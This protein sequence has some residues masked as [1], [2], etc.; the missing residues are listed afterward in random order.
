M[1]SSSFNIPALILVSILGTLLLGCMVLSIVFAILF[2][3]RRN[4][5]YF[6]R[7]LATV[8]ISIICLLAPLSYMVYGCVSSLSHLSTR[9]EPYTPP[10]NNGGASQ[11]DYIDFLDTNGGKL[12]LIEVDG[13]G[14]T[15]VMPYGEFIYGS[16]PT[17]LVCD[18]S[19]INLLDY[20]YE[21]AVDVYNKLLPSSALT[22]PDFYFKET[23]YAPNVRN[24]CGQSP[25]FLNV[26]GQI[27]EYRK[28]LI[29]YPDGQINRNWYEVCPVKWITLSQDAY[30]IYGVS[31][32]VLDVTYF[33]NRLTN[34]DYDITHIN[35]YLNKDMFMLL[36]SVTGRYPGTKDI[37]T[38]RE[39][40]RTINLPTF[41]D[42]QNVFYHDKD[43]TKNIFT[44]YADDQSRIVHP[45]GYNVYA[46]NNNEPNYYSDVICM[47]SDEGNSE[48]ASVYARYGNSM[49]LYNGLKTKNFGVRPTIKLR[50]SPISAQSA[51][52]DG[53][54]TIQGQSGNSTGQNVQ[55]EYNK[56][57]DYH[58]RVEYDEDG[59]EIY[60]ARDPHEYVIVFDESWGYQSYTEYKCECGAIHY[61]YNDEGMLSCYDNEQRLH[62]TLSGVNYTATINIQEKRKSGS[63]IDSYT[64]QVVNTPEGCDFK[65][66]YDT[67]GDTVTPIT[68]RYEDGYA[69]QYLWTLS[70]NVYAYVENQPY[71]KGDS[72]I[73]MIYNY[74][75][76]KLCYY[77]DEITVTPYDI[78]NYLKNKMSTNTYLVTNTDIPILDIDED[79]MYSLFGSDEYDLTNMQIEPF[80]MSMQNLSVTIGEKYIEEIKYVVNPPQIN[81]SNSG[82]KIKI[83]SVY[84]NQSYFVITIT[85]SDIFTSELI[86]IEKTA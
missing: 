30:Y 66:I 68:V 34:T 76:P 70:S 44:D 3:K 46:K 41:L 50:K 4:R 7:S 61:E 67:S 39:E 69:N 24:D 26:N 1:G 9:K 2:I 82:S 18:S 23:V 81:A 80:T 52:Q 29:V 62:R 21:L 28:M 57:D 15:N 36:T 60:R 17:N 75:S 86:E 78:G 47:T 56:G 31:E 42:L 12:Q 59:N 33:D 54:S 40:N 8:I 22:F 14:A 43:L 10:S 6:D 58:I 19:L 51:P 16:Y 37:Y 35:D 49:Y 83:N 77:S 20:E 13:Y 11:Q 74:L 5:E 73:D 27:R 65:E 64:L 84:Q 72:I 79:T 63:L 25:V 85:I 38:V 48:A 53:F 71:I 55:Y 32:Q 45:D